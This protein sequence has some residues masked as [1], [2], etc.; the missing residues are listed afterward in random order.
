[1]TSL[2]SVARLSARYN[3]AFADVPWLTE[4][5]LRTPAYRDH[6][7]WHLYTVQIDFSGIR[8]T[9]TQVMTELRKQ[10]IGCQVLYIPVYLQPWYRQTYGYAHG[11]CPIAEDYYR[12]ALSLP[13]YP[14]LTDADVQRVVDAVHSLYG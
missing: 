8:K 9:R 12:R 10:G 3:A 4:P 2:R 1:M 6:V 11:K 7:S 13:L 14:A 5:G